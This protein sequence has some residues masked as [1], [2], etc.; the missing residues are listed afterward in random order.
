MTVIVD[1]YLP[2][3]IGVYNREIG[4]LKNSE[5]LYQ[6]MHTNYQP[7]TNQEIHTEVLINKIRYTE[8]KVLESLGV[9]TPRR[10]R[11]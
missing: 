7:R 6:Q 2:M 4:R 9:T 1:D 8:R 5:K 11:N 3:G 10:F